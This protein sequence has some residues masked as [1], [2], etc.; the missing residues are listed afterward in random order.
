MQE[1]DNTTSMEVVMGCPCTPL[2]YIVEKETIKM[3]KLETHWDKQSCLKGRLIS[4]YQFYL[5]MTMLNTLATVGL[6]RRIHDYD[7]L[8]PSRVQF[9]SPK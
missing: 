9:F 3:Y 7:G 4:C 5:Y 6:D 2:K 8:L 1:S